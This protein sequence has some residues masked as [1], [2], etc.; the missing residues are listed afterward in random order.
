MGAALLA[1]LAERTDTALTLAF[2]RDD[3]PDLAAC[4]V[5]IDFSTPEA[6]VALAQRAA[7]AGAPALVIGSTG[8]SQQQRLEIERA[9][10]RIPLVLS[11]NFSLGVNVLIGLVRQAARVLG[12]EDFDIEIL[13][14]HHRRKRDAPSGTA[15]MLGDA[16]AAGRGRPLAE[17]RAAVTEGVGEPRRIGAIDFA[18]LRGGGLV[19][20]HTVLFAGEDEVLT[21][22]HSARDRALFARGAVQAALWLRGRPP[23]LY[24]M[25]DVLGFQA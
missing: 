9:S 4:E 24:D 21:L 18:A 20:E 14:A 11:G 6:S 1:V 15:L 17:L 7:E 5:V 3:T 8:L 10:A 23:G 19:G 22:S 12:P 2:D 13:D 25:Q 16:A